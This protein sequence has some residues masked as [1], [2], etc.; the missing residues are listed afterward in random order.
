MGWGRMLEASESFGDIF[1][2]W[3]VNCLLFVIPVQLHPTE[4]FAILVHCDLI[5]LFQGLFEVFGV[6]E[7]DSFDTEIINY[8]TEDDLSLFVSPKA[9]HELALVVPF[10]VEAFCK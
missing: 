5:V 10:E 9:G 1:K 3:Q 7:T 4:E 8:E 6:G 2:H